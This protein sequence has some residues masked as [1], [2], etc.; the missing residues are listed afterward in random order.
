MNI[1][2]SFSLFLGARFNAAVVA[3]VLTLTAGAHPVVSTGLQ[4]YYPF[5]GNT[6]DQSGNSLALTLSGAALTP[7]RFGV[8]N[9]SLGF[10]GNTAIASL[11]YSLA[12]KSFSVGAWFYQPIFSPTEGGGFAQGNVGSP[13][14]ALRFMTDYYFQN[15]LTFHFWYDPFDVSTAGR[16]RANWIHIFATFDNITRIRKVYIDGVLVATNVAAYG[17]SG[18]GP[19]QFG[20]MTGSFDEVRVYNRALSDAEVAEI[21]SSELQ[22]NPHADCEALLVELLAEVTALNAENSSLSQQ[23]TS[24]NQQITALQTLLAQS[25]GESSALQEQNNQA[26]AGLDEIWR[27]LQLPPGQRSSSASYTGPLGMKVNQ[28]IKALVSPPG[29]TSSNGK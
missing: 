16:N 25:Q 11:N 2:S 4:A 5:N 18:S 24:L 8:P 15:N 17:F 10:S 6:N 21:H 26:A 27:L 9:Q 22:Q 12:N 20:F 1:P 28:I 14:L 3:L 13:G 7:D 19:L 29:K 23:L